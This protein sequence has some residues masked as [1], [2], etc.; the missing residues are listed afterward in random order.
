MGSMTVNK[1]MKNKIKLSKMDLSTLS[2]VSVISKRFEILLLKRP[3]PLRPLIARSQFQ[4]FPIRG[5]IEYT[6]EESP[7]SILGP[8]LHLL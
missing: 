2:M 4:T 1:T 5:V 8:I 3:R 7:L 6:L